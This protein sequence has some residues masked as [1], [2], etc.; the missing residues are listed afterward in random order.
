MTEEWK[1][2]VNY[3]NYK[4]SNFGN[5]MNKHDKILKPR[6]DKD[7]YLRLG[8]YDNN[9]KQHTCGVHRLVLQ[10][11][12]PTEEDLECDHIN[13]DKSDNRLCN[14]RWV[15]S[16]QQQLHRRKFVGSTSKYSGVSKNNGRGKKWRVVCYIKSKSYH[17]G[18]FDD[19][20]EA[21]KAYNDFIISHNLQDY[22]ILNEII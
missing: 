4:V 6:F 9:K 14:L 13:H 17:I 7:G 16:S 21:G 8:L 18:F 2:I 11:F 3:K 12:Q 20:H 5:V 1:S 10:V 15:T 19:E 22:V